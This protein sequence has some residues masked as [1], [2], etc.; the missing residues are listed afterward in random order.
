[1]KVIVLSGKGGTGKSSLTSSLALELS[2]SREKIV[3][4]DADVD[5]PNQHI[6][7]P[8]KTVRKDP[9]HISKIAVFDEKKGS[10]PA[11]CTEVCRFGA[12]KMVDGKIVVDK[13]RCTGCGACVLACPGGFLKL[14][15]KF[16]GE[17]IVRETKHFPLIYGRLEPG[18]SGSGRMIF[19]AKK[20]ADEIAGKRNAG[21]TLVDAPAGIGCPV[22]AAVTGCDYAVGI[23]EPTLPAMK[24]LERALEVV[25]HFRIP[26]S[27]VMNKEGISKKHE[28]MIAKKFGKRLI[29]RIPYDEEVCR[30]LAH[31]L[32]PIRGK[33]KGAAAFKNAAEEIKTAIREGM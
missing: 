2:S 32:P 31:G 24:N 27:V 17:L 15:S 12:M 10:P 14:V 13:T 26:F 3:V 22:I 19:E 30:L 9:L 21:L 28:K 33:G 5:C 25:K 29:S 18:E 4:V 7:F 23:V 1:M 20:A 11:R 16:T 6:L 8:G